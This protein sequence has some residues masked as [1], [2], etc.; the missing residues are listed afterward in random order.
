M[1][2][3]TIRE[4][5]ARVRSFYQR[6]ESLKALASGIAALQGALAGKH[7]MPATELRGA[8]R[9]MAQTL[10][11]DEA[12]T[13]AAPG[14]LNYQPG[15][16]KV[17]LALLTVTEQNLRESQDA[18]SYEVALAR[19][20][21]MDQFLTKGLRSL[22][23]GNATEADAAFAEAVKCFRDELRLYAIIGRALL[24]AGEVRRSVPYLKKGVELAPQDPI[25]LELCK[26]AQRRRNER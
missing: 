7:N 13:M 17:L 20:L 15:Q 25:M 6:S 16:E 12:I 8:L 21:R 1:D 22:Q 14:P 4:H 19:K 2:A 3:R 5:L 9:E 18:E 24:E 11:R 10:S 23:Q 26:E